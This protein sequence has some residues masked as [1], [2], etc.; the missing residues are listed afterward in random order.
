VDR[1]GFEKHFKGILNRFK[2][3]N[4][5]SLFL[6]W[7]KPMKNKAINLNAVYIYGEQVINVNG[8]LRPHTIKN[9]DCTSRRLQLMVVVL[10]LKAPYTMA[11]N[12]NRMHLPFST[13]IYRYTA[14]YGWRRLT[15]A[16]T[17]LSTSMC[18]LSNYP[19]S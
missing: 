9:D 14:V 8:C 13:V 3:Q 12:G 16:Q 1:E 11:V 17:A 18:T 7:G 6:H 4:H 5:K 10:D 19:I 2:S 15:W